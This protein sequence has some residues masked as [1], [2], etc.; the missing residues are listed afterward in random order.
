MKRIP[1]PTDHYDEQLL[2][3]DEQICALLKQRKVLSN[4]KP[5]LPPNDVLSNWAGKYDLYEEFLLHFFETMRHEHLFKSRIEPT[6]FRK[7]LSVLKA[8][9]IDERIYSVTVIRQYENASVI[10]LHV[11]WDEPNDSRIDINNKHHLKNFELY[12]GEQY[13]CRSDRAGGSTGHYTYNFIVS[14][15]VPDDISGLDLIF[16]E[17][18]DTLKEKETGLEIVMHIE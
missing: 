14:P 17:Y 16:K 3:V 4:N 11:D 5:G 6:G 13:D 15:P 7:H 18:S 1:R 8:I 9:E 12:I 2:Q 10:Q